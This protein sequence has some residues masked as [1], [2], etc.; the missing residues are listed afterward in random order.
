MPSS[1]A[2][3]NPSA[4]TAST[5]SR[6]SSACSSIRSAIVSQPSRLPISGTP[7]PPQSDSSL[8]QT[9]WTTSSAWACST[10]FA[11]AGS[12]S[13][14]I[15]ELIVGGRSVTTPSRAS[16]TPCDQLVERLDEL[17]DAVLEQLLGHV[18]HVDAGVG[19]R[20]ERRADGSWSP[21]APL[22]LELLG[23]RQ[24]RG[25]RHRVDGVR[26]HQRRPRTWSPGS[27][28]SSRPVEAHSGR[29]TG[30]PASRSAR[31][32]VAVEELLEAHVGG[33]RVGDRG[34]ARAGPRARAPRGACRPR[35]PRARRRSSRPSGRP[36][37]S[38][39]S[40][41]RSMPRM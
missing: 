10:R 17:L 37:D 35:S 40:W 15:D 1:A 41:R 39:A 6:R 7:G 32:A 22:D 2:S 19:E 13:S 27:A 24:Q 8:L 29:C 36:C 26:R 25:H 3:V 23:A 20:L 14:G 28:G 38:P 34:H 5:N 4:F 11:I 12:S 18:A 9:R 21:V 30:A 16:S 31:E 33:A